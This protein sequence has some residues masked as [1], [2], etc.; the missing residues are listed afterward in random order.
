MWSPFGPFWSVKYLNFEQKLPIWTPHHIFLKSRQP[1]VTK[2]PYYVL[3]PKGSQKKVISSALRIS[4]A[5]KS[6]VICVCGMA[7]IG[8]LYLQKVFLKYSATILFC[9]VQLVV[10]PSF[11]L[12]NSFWGGFRRLIFFIVLYILVLSFCMFSSSLMVFLT[13]LFSSALIMM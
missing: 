8:C 13:F 11:P 2:N 7:L 4:S 9:F 12:I 1:E 5:V 3:S 6:V 10:R